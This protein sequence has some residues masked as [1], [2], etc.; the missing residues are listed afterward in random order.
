MFIKQY[1]L[2]AMEN[3]SYLIACDK[4]KL[5]AVIDPQEDYGD[6][7]RDAQDEGL[8]IVMIIHTHGH[9][10]HTAGSRSLKDE[11]SA[12]IVM[13]EDDKDRFA[14]ADFYIDE[15]GALMLGETALHIFH[16][17]GHTPGG[18][19]I[20][21]EKNLFTGDT[22]FAGDSG[23]TDLKGG[24]RPTLGASIRRIMDELPGDTKV[25]P[26]HNIGGA[27]TTLDEE[28]KNNVNA[29]EYGFKEDD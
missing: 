17:P 26:G 5:A 8:N 11:V 24:D 7:I 20:Y 29:E 19:C 13:H 18:I 25:Y 23:R 16:T 10:D 4:T 2:G 28:K 15:E 3:F 6:I 14:D 27:V 22:L 1:K 21:H 12:N 9:A